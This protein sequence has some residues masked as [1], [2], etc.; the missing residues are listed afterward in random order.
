MGN[1]PFTVIAAILFL[2]ASLI[3]AYRLITRFRVVAGTHALPMWASIVVIVVG[4][5]L[6]W[7][8]F[9]EARR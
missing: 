2:L 4:L 5:I 7:G 3:H 9:R 6:A 8:L 1:K